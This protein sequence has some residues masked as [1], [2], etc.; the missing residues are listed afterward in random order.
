MQ[1]NIYRDDN[2]RRA[3]AVEAGSD[4]D[5]TCATVEKL[6]LL[7]QVDATPV[8]EFSPR[9]SAFQSSQNNEY[10]QTGLPWPYAKAVVVH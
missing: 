8:S 1:Y 10:V 3:I 5:R 7:G 6:A 2:E 4:Y 9:S